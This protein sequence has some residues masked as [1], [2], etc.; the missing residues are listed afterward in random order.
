MFTTIPGF[1]FL[2]VFCSTALEPSASHAADVPGTYVLIPERSDDLNTVINKATARLNFVMRPIAR[3]RLR[4]TNFAYKDIMIDERPD[5]IVISYQGRAPVRA[6]ADGAIVPWR[7]EDGEK[8]QVWMK[9][10]GGVLRHHFQ[11][12]DGERLNEFSWSAN[13][14]TMTLSVT[15]I[16]P[17]LPEPVRYR[18]VYLRSAKETRGAPFDTPLVRNITARISP[19]GRDVEPEVPASIRPLE[20]IR[21]IRFQHEVAKDVESCAHARTDHRDVERI[22][23]AC[24]PDVG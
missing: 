22:G 10:E 24:K 18:L 14:D 7:R 2:S 5:T 15:L 13:Q 23:L 11:A 12:D 9:R 19:A 1:V 4:G 21:V 16:S 20:R 8:F 3:S 6:P 17:R